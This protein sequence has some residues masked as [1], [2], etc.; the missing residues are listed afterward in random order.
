[1]PLL[2]YRIREYIDP[3]DINKHSLR[4]M[5]LVAIR[6]QKNSEY[7]DDFFRIA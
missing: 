1:M 5:R 2:P 7:I 4:Y 3:E 6:A